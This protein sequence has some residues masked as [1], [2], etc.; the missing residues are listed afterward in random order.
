M[1]YLLGFF[2]FMHGLIHA[3]YFSIPNDPKYPMTADKSW[4][5]TKMNL[6]IATVKPII[7]GLAV[8]AF[9]GFIL[10]ALSYL[11]W[12]V[13]NDWFK[14]LTIVSAIASLAVIILTWN[15]W[16]VVGALIDVAILY[17]ILFKK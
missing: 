6:P 14:N 9:V 15:T 17:F 8:V 13:P 11:G 3:G 7:V 12:L 16:F 2:F 10:V 4:L 1:K 5:V